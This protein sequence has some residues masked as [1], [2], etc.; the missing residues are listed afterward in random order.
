MCALRIIRLD[1]TGVSCNV[2]IAVAPLFSI[3]YLTSVFIFDRTI[4]RFFTF[5]LKA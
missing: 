2:Y 5:T 1:I 4:A 3:E